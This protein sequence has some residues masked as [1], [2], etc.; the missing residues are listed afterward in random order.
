MKTKIGIIGLLVLIAGL[1]LSLELNGS[2]QVVGSVSQ[3]SEYNSTTTIGMTTNDNIAVGYG[4]FGSIIITGLNTGVLTVYDGTSTV[5]TNT[6]LASFPASTPVG[7]Y[8]FD[9][10]Y[11]K[12]L[13]VA[14]TGIAPT[15]TITY[16]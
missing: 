4:T 7:T 12:G 3:G 14:F 6:V 8:T 2:K 1:L 5:N 11:Y 16:R 13:L 15:S 9:S 10:R